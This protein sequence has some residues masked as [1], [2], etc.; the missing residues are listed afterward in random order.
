[1][2]QGNPSPY[3]AWLFVS[4]I[5]IMTLVQATSAP[6][7]LTGL[8]VEEVPTDSAAVKAGVKVGDRILSYDS[9]PLASP[10]AL[11]AA[12]ENTTGKQEVA[13]LIR[14][15]KETLLLRAP[16]GS[17][18]IWVRP[19]LPPAVQ[20]LYEKGRSARIANRFDDVIS[21]WSTA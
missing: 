7:E 9:R 1:M 18:G 10:A 17:L 16:L 12:E 20:G 19:E 6:S 14:R 4:L 5:M 8:V 13:L 3:R 21:S 11:Q 2:R 15:A